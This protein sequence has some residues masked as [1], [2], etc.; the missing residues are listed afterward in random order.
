MNR[1]G[2]ITLD[3][4]RSL[5]NEMGLPVG[6]DEGDMMDKM[7]EDGSGSLEKQEWIEWWLNRYQLI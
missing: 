4:L 7:D 2:Y 3:R 1:D 6:D 5:C